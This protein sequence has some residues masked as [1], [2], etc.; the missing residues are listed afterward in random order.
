MS[1]VHRLEQIQK[2]LQH[3]KK[4]TSPP[5]QSLVDN[6]A[7]I[8]RK[9]FG[10]PDQNSP[11]LALSAVVTKATLRLQHLQL[12]LH[13]HVLVN[14]LDLVFAAQPP[15]NVTLAEQLQLQ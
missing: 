13:I 1:A 12:L 11:Q 5:L 9:R 10:K 14:D 15:T 3:K 8:F 7:H 4:Q 2:E 6:M